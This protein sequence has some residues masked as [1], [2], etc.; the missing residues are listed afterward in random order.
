MGVV[1]SQ[2]LVKFSAI[3][4]LPVQFTA[5]LPATTRTGYWTAYNIS[6]CCFPCRALKVC[7]G[8]A[9]HQGQQELR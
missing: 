7:R 9:E 5:H 1:E 2:L 6:L 4:R 8:R 3:S